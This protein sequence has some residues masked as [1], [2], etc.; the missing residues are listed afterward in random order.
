MIPYPN[1]NPA[2]ITVE[3]V[4]LSLL[5]VFLVA[6]HQSPQLIA[7]QG[8]LARNAHPAAPRVVVVCNWAAAPNS[9]N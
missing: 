2:L 8:P 9:V 3:N 1:P 5:L 7:V 4:W 6:S